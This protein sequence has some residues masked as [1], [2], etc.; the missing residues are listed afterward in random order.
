[1]KRK[2]ILFGGSFDPIHNGHLIVARCAIEHIGAD[3][4]VLIPA[5]CSPHKKVFPEAIAIDRLKMIELAIAGEKVMRVSDC[6]INREPPSY[7]IDTVHYFR[8]EYGNKA[9]LYWL[10]GV[11]MLK[12]LPRWYRIDE[13]LDECNLCLMMRPGVKRLK[14]DEFVKDF[15]QERVR[16]LEQNTIPNPLIDVSSTEI[17]RRVGM[18]EDISQ[19]VHLAV[20]AYIMEHHLYAGHGKGI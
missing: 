8:K 18:G 19:M 17:R 1:M 13:L 2:I 11:D 16:K 4:L 14:L 10:V 5:R 7:T 15:G 6:E 3:E 20:M 9:Q 12:D